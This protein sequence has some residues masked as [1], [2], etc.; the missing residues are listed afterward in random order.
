MNGAGR[1]CPKWLDN[2]AQ[3]H[4]GDEALAQLALAQHGVMTGG[5]LARL[6][7]TRQAVSERAATGRLHRVH[8]GVYALVPPQL[9]SRNGHFMA[10]VLACGPGA[11]LSHASAAWLLDLRPSG[12]VKVDITVPTRNGRKRPGIR[13]HRATTLRSTDV[14]TA[15]NI[16]CTSIARTI[17]DLAARQ[18]RRGVERILDR[19]SMLEVIDVRALGDQIANN[20]TARAARV[21]TATLSD[22]RP[23]STATES[24][25]EEELLAFTRELHLP[26]PEVQPWLDLGDG[27][28]PIRP[29]FLWRAPRVIVEADG[30]G[31]HGTRG[32]FEADRRRDQR[33]SAAG[34][35]TVRITR[36][37][38]Q[39]E[40]PRLAR[41]L[42]HLAT[43]C[44]AA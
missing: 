19:A 44:A 24:P 1:K 25:L 23:G 28:Q 42:L 4:Q 33:A 5:Q 30:Y 12:A 14:I 29:D 31:P 13:I 20:P 17:F 34:Y 11:A 32:S 43:G 41:L 3:P 36:R 38:L 27:D 7:L 9:L 22:H 40:R 18:D 6:G 15:E 8:H 2:F 21:L 26:D 35:R 16:P 10:A 39:D 37:Q